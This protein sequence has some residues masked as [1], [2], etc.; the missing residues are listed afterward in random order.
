MQIQSNKI[1]NSK[2]ILEKQ[3]GCDYQ[4]ALALI[5]KQ[6]QQKLDESYFDIRMTG[7]DFTGSRRFGHPKEDSDLDV[8]M[9]YDILSGTAREDDV[10]NCLHDKADPICFNGMLVDVDP[11][12]GG[13]IDALIEIDSKYEKKESLTEDTRAGLLSKSKSADLYKN[14]SFGK[15]R[16]DRRMKSKVANQVKSY[17]RIDM[18]LLFKQDVLEVVIPVIG[19]SGSYD[20]TLRLDGVVAEIA[21][22]IKSNKNRFEFRTVVQSVTKVLNT[23]DVKVKCTCP[24]FKFRYSHNL[25]LNG[26]SVDDT[27][28]DP[29]PGKTGVTAVMKGQG[30]KHIMLVLSNLS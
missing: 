6:I 28:K 16:F 29:G 20:V 9:T 13:D 30:C 24:D 12:E 4:L 27:S 15:N 26:N 19:E 23:S 5:E 2:L 8:K 7:I 21:K 18:N 11:I 1:E 10:F 14:T 22:N 25:I 3:L 17:N